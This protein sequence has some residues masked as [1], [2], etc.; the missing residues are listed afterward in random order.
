[1]RPRPQRL[2][3]CPRGPMA[4]ALAVTLALLLGLS[5]AQAAETPTVESLLADFNDR[6]TL[7][8]RSQQT[9]E[10]L[11]KANAEQKLEAVKQALVDMA[12]DTDLRLD[13]AAFLDSLG[14]LHESSLLSTNSDISG[15]RVLDIKRASGID[16]AE[17]EVKMRSGQSCPGARPN[18]RRQ[19][20]ISVGAN[21]TNANPDL[22]MGD[23]YLGELNLLTEQA[24]IAALYGSDNW[25]VRSQNH[26]E[27]AYDRY[28]SGTSADQARYR[29]HIVLRAEYAEHEQFANLPT[30]TAFEPNA[31][32]S[33]LSYG[34]EA[35]YNGLAK[36]A[37]A[38]PAL[39]YSKPWPEQKYSYQLA[40]FDREQGAALWSKKVAMRYPEVSRGYLKAAMPE[41]LKQR[42]GE[43]TQQFV[44]EVSDFM[45]CREEFY[46]L[47]PQPG[48][49][50]LVK[51]NAGQIAG[52]NVGDQFLISADKN[53]LNQSLSMEGLSGLGL[54]KVQSVT[55]HTAIL[56]YV[57]GPQWSQKAM[58]ARSVAMHF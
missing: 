56:K 40:L 44:A 43:I 55:A 34:L 54:A 21:V 6:Y 28:L 1:M 42:L 31:L 30:S 11:A 22:R 4:A 47:I 49:E 57:A 36:L 51:I 33:G 38:V 12:L 7:Q 23:H 3:L 14:M 17:L 16:V 41:P 10:S 50:E 24:L 9:P 46:K 19:A 29:F 58:L 48:T 8:E 5:R 25:S 53:I 2:A 35:G 13:S 15:L 45:E 37:E 20:V 18:N 26:Y 39:S 27:S 52:I 32:V